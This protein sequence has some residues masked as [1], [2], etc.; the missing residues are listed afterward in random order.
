VTVVTRW[1]ARPVQRAAV[2]HTTGR[3]K[4]AQTPEAP[5]APEA[6]EPLKSLAAQEGSAPTVE[7]LAHPNRK[8]SA[9][10]VIEATAAHSTTAALLAKRP[11]TLGL[12]IECVG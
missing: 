10:Q 7:P 12:S 2:Q 4:A 1:A 6:L 3:A 9:A 5:E 8:R 11:S